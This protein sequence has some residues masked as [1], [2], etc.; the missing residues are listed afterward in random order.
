MC[1]NNFD[2]E[3]VQDNLEITLSEVVDDGLYCVDPNA[4][5]EAAL[6]ELRAHEYTSAKLVSSEHARLNQ[7]E[8]LPPLVEY[9]RSS[10]Q[11]TSFE[12]NHGMTTTVDYQHGRVNPREQLYLNNVSIR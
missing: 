5:V 1:F 8:S 6:S 3:L 9:T 2:S 7:S 10:P 4:S 12:Y 11:Q